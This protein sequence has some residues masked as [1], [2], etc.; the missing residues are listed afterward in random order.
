MSE[1]DCIGD[2]NV[3]QT[4]A[5]SDIEEHGHRFVGNVA[6]HSSRTSAPVPA[7]APAPAP[8][9]GSGRNFAAGVLSN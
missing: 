5:I 2:G 8:A 9:P 1:D 4:I 3:L 6:Q 7:P